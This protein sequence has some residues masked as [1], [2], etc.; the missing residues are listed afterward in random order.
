MMTY[1]PG[2]WT[3]CEGNIDST[4]KKDALEAVDLIDPLSEFLLCRVVS[5]A[6]EP[7]T[8]WDSIAMMGRLKVLSDFEFMIFR[9]NI[10][11]ICVAFVLR[12]KAILPS[13]EW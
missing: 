8:F 5:R 10:S 12:G 7:I 11:A 6:E 1:L 4:E 2:S 13:I 3:P 9:I